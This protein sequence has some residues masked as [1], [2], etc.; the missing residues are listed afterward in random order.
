VADSDF[1]LVEIFNA[2]GIAKGVGEFL[3]FEDFANVGFFV[4][5]MKTLDAA[6]DEVVSDGTIS[7]EHEFFDDAVGDVAFTAADV[8]HA[9]LFVEFDD[10]LGEIE[11]DGAV[12]FAAGIEEQS[13]AAHDKEMMVK[14]G[15]TLRHFGVAGENL[16]DVGVGHALGGTD[17]AGNHDGGEHVSGGIEIHDGAH[18]QA[19]FAGIERAD[20]VGERF[21]EHGNGAVDEIDGI[22][23]EAGFAIERRFG[24]NIVSDVGNVNLEEPSAIVAA[25]DVNGVVEITSGFA[26]DGDDGKFAK[27][28]AASTIGFGDGVSDLFGVV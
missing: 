4:D 15:V 12:V 16:V 10:G 8:G 9:P 21:G 20:A 27:I 26:V 2:E 5:A 22:A 14:V 23:A 6:V 13:E 17:D 24:M 7:G 28:F 18:D 11:I 19:L 3:E 25:L 1:A